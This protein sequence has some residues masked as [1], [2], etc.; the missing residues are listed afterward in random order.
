MPLVEEKQSPLKETAPTL[1]ARGEIV[2]PSSRAVATLES[3]AQ[4]IAK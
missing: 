4:E 2:T 3:K 1:K